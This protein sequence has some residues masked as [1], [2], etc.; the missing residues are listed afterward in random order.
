[1]K[2]RIR[3]IIH[4]EYYQICENCH[5]QIYLSEPTLASIERK[6]PRKYQFSFVTVIVLNSD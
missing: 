1:M 4:I 3:Q 6:R 5:R 2:K